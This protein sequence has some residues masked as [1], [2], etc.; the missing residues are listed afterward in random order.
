MIEGFYPHALN[1]SR[2]ED[3]SGEIILLQYH[4]IDNEGQFED[5]CR[6]IFDI[7]RAPF[8]DTISASDRKLE[9]YKETF[10][11]YTMPKG[12]FS[13]ETENGTQAVR[14]TQQK[15]I[16]RPCP[17][18]W[19]KFALFSIIP[20]IE[21]TDPYLNI[22][23]EVRDRTHERQHSDLHKYLISLRRQFYCQWF[24]SKLELD[25]KLRG[26]FENPFDPGMSGVLVP[27]L[28][29]MAT[30]SQNW[31]SDF[32]WVEKMD[33]TMESWVKM[34]NVDSCGQWERFFA[35]QKRCLVKF[36]KNLRLNDHTYWEN[37][38]L[39]ASFAANLKTYSS[40][41]VLL[42]GQLENVISVL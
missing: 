31:M 26:Y 21:K 18:I 4:A 12:T 24:I 36:R 9:K 23:V 29:E 2:S 28:P 20:T 32:D 38:R 15:Y 7:S 19:E 1:L 40:L 33:T 16:Y 25:V 27:F 37:E 5:Q 22:F 41:L 3:E 30:D 13:S 39:D 17:I 10:R 8:N 14:F 35:Y 34:L 11:K 42:I 6:P